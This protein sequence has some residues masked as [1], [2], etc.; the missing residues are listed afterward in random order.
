MKIYNM[1]MF[2]DDLGLVNFMARSSNFF[3]A[4]MAKAKI[5]RVF[6]CYERHRDNIIDFSAL[7]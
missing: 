6:L 4:S 3:I 7:R 2:W 1:M 5:L